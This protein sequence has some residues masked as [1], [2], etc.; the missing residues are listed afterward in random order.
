M[1]RGLSD[2]SSYPH[3]AD[4]TA[5]G[6]GRYG[7]LA[8]TVVLPNESHKRFAR[9]LKTLRTQLQPAN[10]V[11]KYLAEGMAAARWRRLR[12]WGLERAII[13]YESR[14]RT[15]EFTDLA[16]SEHSAQTAHTLRH[17]ADDSRFL[18]DLSRHES[19]Y[20]RQYGRALKCLLHLRA[21]PQKSRLKTDPEALPC[22]TKHFF[23]QT[24]PAISLIPRPKLLA[25]PT[26]LPPFYP[27]N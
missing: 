5:K 22:R 8:R 1:K 11:E 14:T 9:V 12:A 24:N 17:F 6:A 7:F 27:P 16:P 3:E 2:S 19:R 20:D 15:P 21:R 4:R 26:R 18:E 25:N 10:D 23:T 13:G